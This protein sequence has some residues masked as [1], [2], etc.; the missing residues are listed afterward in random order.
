ML[1]QKQRDLLIFIH[2]HMGDSGI[3]PS[4]EE[5]KDALDLKSKSG[6]H[7][8][9]SGLEERGFLKRLP[10]RARALEIT[11][12]PEGYETANTS[13]VMAFK[14]RQKPSDVVFQD[15][16]PVHGLGTQNIPLCG[17]IAAGTPIEAIQHEGQGIDIPVS[18]LGNGEYYAL[19]IEGDSMM[20]AGIH[21]MD[22]IIVERCQ[23]AQNG[24]IVVALIDDQEATLKRFRKEGDKI[25]LIPE[26]PAYEVRIIDAA[27]VQI[28][29]KLVSLY[30]QYH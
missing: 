9:I 22:T 11:R 1:T 17:K 3:A 15:L 23:T 14:P 24:E 29:G 25:A 30:R 8:L 6:I 7:R 20:N 10:H 2:E 28:Q 26:N 13:N 5:M 12:L 19:T 16:N 27:R 21:D 18:M 4:Y